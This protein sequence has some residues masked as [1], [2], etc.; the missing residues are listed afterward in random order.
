[1][2]FDVMPFIAMASHV[3]PVSHHKSLH[4][5]ARCGMPSFSMLFK[6]KFSFAMACHFI[7]RYVFP[8]Y[9]EIFSEGQ[10]VPGNSRL[11]HGLPCNVHGDTCQSRLYYVVV[12]HAI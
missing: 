10:V 5:M 4:A 11:C 2:A 8:R 9:A 12:I 3:V 7:P 1:M 6:I